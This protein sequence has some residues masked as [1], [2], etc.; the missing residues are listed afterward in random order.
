MNIAEKKNTG[1]CFSLQEPENNL[2]SC[3]G[4]QN[5]KQTKGKETGKERKRPKID[6]SSDEESVLSLSN[7]S[8]DSDAENYGK[9]SP[10]DEDAICLY[11]DGK[12]SEDK[13][14]EKSIQCLECMQWC[15]TECSGADNDMFV[16]EY[17]KKCC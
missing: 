14:G 8:S 5:R 13:K 9:K 11:C 2:P 6:S 4:L 3:S 17:C 15:H 10:N 16:C 12:Y 1:K 7:E